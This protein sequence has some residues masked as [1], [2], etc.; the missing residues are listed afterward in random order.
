MSDWAFTVEIQPRPPHWERRVHRSLA[1]PDSHRS[2]QEDGRILTSSLGL[3]SQRAIA[4]SPEFGSNA[5]VAWAYRGLLSTS[6]LY[7]IRTVVKPPARHY[8]CPRSSPLPSIITAH[9]PSL[10]A[11]LPSLQPEQPT[12]FIRRSKSKLLSHSRIRSHPADSRRLTA[13]KLGIQ[14]I[15]ACRVFGHPTVANVHDAAPVDEAR[16]LSG[17]RTC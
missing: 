1:S 9:V 6:L 12:S 16:S 7:L 2:H 4:G 3:R 10:L 8:L 5:T 14:Q 15:D 17:C 13:S 11:A